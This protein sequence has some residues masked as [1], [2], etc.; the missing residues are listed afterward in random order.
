MKTIRQA[1]RQPIKTFFG[2]LMMTF[3]AAIL[4]ICVGQAIAARA[5]IHE[6][7]NSFTTLGITAEDPVLVAGK[8]TRVN[9]KLPD[10]VA[11]WLEETAEAHPE[12]IKGFV[13]SSTI[14]A[15]IP[16]L[17]ALN[18]TSGGAITNIL[19]IYSAMPSQAKI[20]QHS[21]VGMP[22]TCGLLTFVLE[23]LGEPQPVINTV[24][25]GKILTQSDFATREEYEKYLE[26]VET[27]T[28]ITGYTIQLSGTVTG[29]VSLAEGYRDPVGKTLRV[30]ILVETLEEYEALKL[31]E[32]GEYIAF[33][34]EYF[35]EDW[36]LRCEIAREEE[37]EIEAFDPERMYVLEGETLR[38]WQQNN[39]HN[40][41]YAIY[42]KWL[43][44]REEQYRRANTVSM[45]MGF[46]HMRFRSIRD[47]EGSVVDYVELLERTLT[48]PD[49]TT[50]TISKQ[51][52][53]DRYQLP[54]VARIDTTVEDF[55]AS[56]DGAPWQELLQWS[57]INHQAF[58]VLGVDKLGYVPDFAREKSRVVDGRNFT[59]EELASGARVCLIQETLAA[60]SG[61]SVG[62]TITLNIYQTDNNLPYM[63]LDGSYV[64]SASFYFPTTPFTE[65]AEYTVVGLWRGETLFVNSSE[66]ATGLSPNTVIV[67][68]TSVQTEMKLRSR[69]HFNSVILHNGTI[70]E[71]RKLASEVGY[72]D[73]FVFHDQGYSEIAEGFHNYDDMA[74]KVLKIGAAVYGVLLLL[75]LLLFPTS[76]RKAVQTMESMGETY[77]KRYG[78]IVAYS[79]LHLIPAA[80]LG[81]IIGASAWHTV[82]H[83]LIQSADSTITM[84]LDLKVLVMI[85][86]AQ[87]LVALLLN[88]FAA[89]PAAR[90]FGMTKKR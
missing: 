53:I 37:V 75:F 69:I 66:N 12:I 50:E 40:V 27:R 70:D 35:D 73:V 74:E 10:E 90:T 39:P 32:G 47:E 24:K 57:E 36:S 63:L 14:S 21:P 23:E 44:L 58:L 25:L 2:I 77:G 88:A 41:P 54:M 64:A 28:V 20:M 17:T 4:C 1:L 5:T 3:A 84:G 78:H 68:K 30:T 9:V 86:L 31:E 89:L 81:V 67:P 61:I 34:T 51:E 22:Y 55:L 38:L 33:S 72:E 60:A 56:E 15:Y 6:M 65:T 43:L 48:M 18:S 8:E 76:R 62:D 46:P 87:C 85:S 19:S 29:V 13:R 7:E 42:D 52:F 80:V 82:T 16:E 71:Y 26:T 49:G 83:K 11:A 59:E 45:N 79:V